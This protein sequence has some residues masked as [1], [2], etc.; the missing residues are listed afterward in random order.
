MEV[1]RSKNF[2]EPIVHTQILDDNTLVVVDSKTTIR[3]LDPNTLELLDGFKVNIHHRRYK[4]QVI[5]FSSDGKFFVTLSPDCKEAI[6][7]DARTKKVITTIDRHH[8]EVSCIGIDTFNKYMFSCGDDGKTFAIDMQSGKLAFTLP[9]HIDAVNDIVFSTNGNWVATCS[10]DRKISLF[11]I[12]MMTSKH[13]LVAHSDPVI[14]LEFIGNNR[15]FSIDK[16]SN[17]I[18]WDMTT[19]KVLARLDGIHD[20]V[21][22]V[23]SVEENSFLFLGTALGYVLVYDLN[24]YK[25]LSKKYIKLH[26]S[27]T[28]LVFDAATKN[29]IVSNE[30]GDVLVYNIYQGQENIIKF[31]KEKKYLHIQN[32]ID[33]NPLLEY[34][35]IYSRVIKIWDN[36][37]AKAKQCLQSGDRNGAIALFA[38]FKN[39]PAQNKIMQEVLAE[40]IDYARFVDM[41]RQGKLVL[42]Y[43]LIN[44]HPMYKE[45][46]IYNA[47]EERWRKTF[48]LAQKHALDPKGSEKAR[49]ILAP[50]RGISDKTKLMQ[51]LFSQ[52]EV[53]KRFKIALGQKDFKITFELIKLHPFL[54][55]FPEYTTIMNYADTLYIKSQEL[56]HDG[57]TH[58]AIKMLRV[59]IDFPDF[60]LEVK[61]LMTDIESQQNFF[62]A[63]KD[64]DIVLAYNLLNKSEALQ[65]TEDGK[66]LQQKWNKDLAKANGFA[67][68]G[69][70]VGIQD[71][72]K[73]YMNINSKYMSLATIFGWCYMI[74]LELAIDV[75]KDRLIIEEGIKNYILNFGLQDQIL[76]LYEIFIVKFP[77][78][79]LNLE[80]LTKG[81]LSMW[82]PS[83]IVQSILD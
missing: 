81:S 31:L 59:L 38:S 16:R 56:I 18:I 27:V 63:I 53:Y 1:R 19:A 61:E 77:D 40:Y 75:E 71:T 3:Y 21:T 30:E 64:E 50:Y 36:T 49:E 60:T 52:G 15:L 76:S 80:L 33:K 65:S 37:L 2:K 82:R 22:Q 54:R 73:E 10:Y 14:K 5:K 25:Q 43:G 62:K 47:M 35:N 6:L 4:N 32:Q 70:V 78:S 7:Y 8:G 66:Q 74:Q 55:E 45:T 72:L 12:S 29:L 68:E 48:A 17:A 13:R 46:P 26:S 23:L 67:V 57:D 41:A 79:K 24:T 34:T 83:M 39:I 58:S 11:N 28:S 51:E 9:M 20:D 42:A 69:D 44:Q